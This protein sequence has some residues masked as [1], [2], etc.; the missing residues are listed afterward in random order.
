MSATI[1]SIAHYLPP[2]IYNNKYFET[3]LDTN[4]EWIMERTGIAERRFAKE[5]GTSDLIVP[6][7][8]LAM[9]KAG[10][11]PA[12]IDCV[13]VCTV[14]PDFMFPNTAA[15]VQRKLGLTNAWGFDLSAACSGF[16]FGISTAASLVESGTA[17]RV[18]LCGSDKMS[19][20]LD[21]TDRSQAIL[22]GDGAGVCIVEKSDDPEMGVLD[23]IL[24]IDG[25][26]EPFL[27]MKAGGSAKPASKE[28]VENREHYIFQDGQ[29]VFKAAVKGMADVSAEIMEKNNLKPEDVAWL[30]PHQANLRI[31]DAT[32][33]RM[34]LS[35]DKIMINIEKYGNTTAGTIP[36]C[37][38]EWSQKGLLNNGDRII[39]ASFGAG[40]T[41]GAVYM[42]WNLKYK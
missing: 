8:K 38:S 9:E 3:F 12:D 25:N 29:P 32:A 26:G 34:G 15:V 17:K 37:L 28:S 10:Y 1:T 19:S 40:Y 24:R 23:Q 33:R 31:I 4:H 42:R 30:V 6:A 2:D 13:L 20:I 27:H 5:G 36:I 7:A 35:K 18:L 16:L 39:L 21:L 14:T 11:G 41:W 22:F